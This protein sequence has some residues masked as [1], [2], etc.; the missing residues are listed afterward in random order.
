MIGQV[1]EEVACWWWRSDI[2]RRADDPNF[3]PGDRALEE[4]IKTAAKGL[5]QE[6]V[7]QGN[8]EVLGGSVWLESFG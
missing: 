4:G 2:H 7:V 1:R 6:R 5:N 3:E 8:V